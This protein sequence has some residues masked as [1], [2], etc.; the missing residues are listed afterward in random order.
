MHIFLR[1]FSHQNPL[2][3]FFDI[4]RFSPI[5]PQVFP[6]FLILYFFLSPHSQL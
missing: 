6:N 1:A 5:T 3:L 2:Q 4:F